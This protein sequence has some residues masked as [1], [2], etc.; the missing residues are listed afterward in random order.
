MRQLDEFA[1]KIYHRCY[2]IKTSSVAVKVQKFNGSDF[3]KYRVA[4]RKSIKLILAY[5]KHNVTN[6]ID[7]IDVVKVV[8]DFKALI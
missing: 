8:R 1:R 5:K 4:Y 3:K 7:S 6:R 2:S